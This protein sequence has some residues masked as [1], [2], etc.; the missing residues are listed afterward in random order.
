[1]TTNAVNIDDIKETVQA[2][3]KSAVESTGL[4]L[5]PDVKGDLDGMTEKA[6]M[7]M[8]LG[9]SADD[10]NELIVDHITNLADRIRFE[11]SVDYSNPLPPPVGFEGTEVGQW[12]LAL[13]PARRIERYWYRDFSPENLRDVGVYVSVTETLDENNRIVRGEPSVRID[14]EYADLSPDEAR[15]VAA[16]IVAASD[17]VS[18]QP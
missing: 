6:V 5:T 16:R 3:V 18:V 1:M 9:V 4:A 2:L 8:G 15:E 10:A 7:L 12:E 11:A 17:A 14:A 13:M